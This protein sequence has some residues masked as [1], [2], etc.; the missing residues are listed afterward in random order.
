MPHL[1]LEI[2]PWAQ[3]YQQGKQQAVGT[4]QSPTPAQ[5]P[6][7]SQIYSLRVLARTHPDAAAKFAV[8]RGV[9]LESVFDH[10][11]HIE[12]KSRHEV[13]GLENV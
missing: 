1:H 10:I 9:P 11:E 6:T 2:S 8:E 12:I 7:A 13:W 4:Q 5:S 3:C